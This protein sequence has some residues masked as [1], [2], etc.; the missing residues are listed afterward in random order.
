[1]RR[2]PVRP[3]EKL[4]PPIPMKSKIGVIVETFAIIGLLSALYLDYVNN[5]YLQIY[6]SRTVT[7]ILGGIN[8]WTGAILGATS[9][10]TT[11]FL[12]RNKSGPSKSNKR[13]GL[14]ALVGKLHGLTGRQKRRISKLKP[15]LPS[16]TPS[17]PII[18][19]TAKA[20]TPQVEETEES[21]AK[22]S[23]DGAKG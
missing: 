13:G 18:E 11:Y 10:L 4:I 1:M 5:A 21:P 23:A 22:A 14:S 3:E 16:I 8:V 20:S 6:L 7:Q 15:T 2:V 17:S 19:Q 9:F 12:L